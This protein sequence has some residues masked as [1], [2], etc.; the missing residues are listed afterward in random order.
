MEGK[1]YKK[2][3]LKR[4]RTVAAECKGVIGAMSRALMCSRTQVYHWIKT[5]PKFKEVIDEYRGQLL[6]ECL[7][8]ARVLCAGIPKIENNKIVG[9]IERPDSQMIRYFISTLGKEEG[10][11]ESIDI[12]SKGESIKPAPIVIE[13]IDS[14]DKVRKPEEDKEE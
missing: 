7:K 9:W 2:P 8:S 4:F 6:D 14:R 10:F 13:V 11:G 12:T 1:T 5:D 3:T